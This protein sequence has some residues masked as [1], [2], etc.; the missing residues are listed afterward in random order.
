[1]TAIYE[2]KKKKKNRRKSQS[3]CEWNIAKKKK[4]ILSPFKSCTIF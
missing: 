4:N 3:N 2:F 1:M